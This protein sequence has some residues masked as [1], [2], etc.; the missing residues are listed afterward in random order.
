LNLME[1]L[2]K[3]RIIGQYV[4]AQIE[5]VYNFHI[6]NNALKGFVTQHPPNLNYLLR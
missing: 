5:F 4:F 3:S 2:R 6:Y 1:F